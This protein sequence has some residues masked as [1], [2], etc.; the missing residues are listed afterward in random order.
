VGVKDFSPHDLRRTFIS[1]LLDLGADIS[2]M[3]WMEGHVS[4]ETT[5]RIDRRPEAS[6][7]KAAGLLHLPFHGR[8]VK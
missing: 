7:Q 6:K 1:N 8:C 2:T 3:A 4:V 5:A